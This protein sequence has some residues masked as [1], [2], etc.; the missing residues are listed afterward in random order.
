LHD[1]V[2]AQTTVAD[3]TTT[4]PTRV[5]V[6]GMAHED[7][8]IHAEELFPVA[9]ACGQS[10]EQ[11]RS[12]L[13]RLVAEGLFVRHGTGSMARYQATPGGI[14]T[15]TSS[16]ARTRLAYALDAA[17][18]GWDGRWHL[19]AFAIPEDR[20]PARDAFRDRLLRLG[21]APVQ[22]GLYASAL[23]WDR[24][25]RDEAA[26]LGVTGLV[27]VAVT[28]ELEIAGERNARALAARLWPLTEL[29]A[30]YAAFVDQYREVPLALEH[31]RKRKERLADSDFLPA[32]LAMAVAFQECF[33][34]DPLLPPELLP[35][36]WPGKAARELIAVSRRL[37]LNL[38]QAH[39][40]PALFHLF[41]AAVDRL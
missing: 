22:G 24:E 19:V 4:I 7:G 32:A 27:T 30:R 39:G 21:G 1:T 34:R 18:R 12:C 25:V 11:V 16:I 10:A 5:L 29:H 33:E 37:A 15:L 2:V 20:R 26:R 28:D 17:G 9:G 40:R 14:A 35:R 38:R 6:L 23:D 36:P 8:T 41:D 31:M 13:R 3:A